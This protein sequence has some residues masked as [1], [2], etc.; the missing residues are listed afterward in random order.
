MYLG[1]PCY[2][3]A[4]NCHLVCLAIPRTRLLC[5]KKQNLFVLIIFNHKKEIQICSNKHETCLVLAWNV[6]RSLEVLKVWIVFMDKMWY[7]IRKVMGSKSSY[8]FVEYN[9]LEVSA[10]PSLSL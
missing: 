4:I 5:M 2:G 6:C 9:I 10:T 1:P 3:Y 8:K 7:K